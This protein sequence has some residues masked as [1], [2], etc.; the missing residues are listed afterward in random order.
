VANVAEASSSKMVTIDGHQLKLS[1]LDKVL[2]PETGFTKAQIIDYYSNVA[3]TLLGHIKDRPMT[4]HRFPNGVDQPGFYEKN[5][6]SHAPEWIK[7]V[8]VQLSRKTI[9]QILAQNRATVVWMANMAS[10]EMHPLLS[11]FDDGS[12]PLKITFDLDPGPPANITQCCEVAL[13]LRELLQD[14]GLE[15][16]PKTS[17]SKGMQVDVP[18]NRPD[19]TFTQTKPFAHAVARILESQHKQLVVSEMAKVIRKDK[20]FI[21]WSQN[22]PAKT[23][24]APYSLRARTRNW[25]STPLTWDEVHEGASSKD[26]TMLQFETQDVLH[27]IDKLGDLAADVQ[28]LEQKLPELT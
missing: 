23:T 3:P 20:V 18:L 13:H 14:L 8:D 5:R 11:K 22:D 2:F 9:H 16:F 10:L 25:V 27:R 4:L 26:E 17:G 19:V 7:S 24:V 12:R 15:C 28:S 6:P 21:D 1:N